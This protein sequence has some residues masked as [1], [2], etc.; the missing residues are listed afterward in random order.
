MGSSPEILGVSDCF[1]IAFHVVVS[2]LYFESM[3]LDMYFY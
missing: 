3:D 2:I 1:E